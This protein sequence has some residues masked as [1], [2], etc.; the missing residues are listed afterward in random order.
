MSVSEGETRYANMTLL[1]EGAPASGLGS[2]TW[3]S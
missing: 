1:T 2:M 3:P